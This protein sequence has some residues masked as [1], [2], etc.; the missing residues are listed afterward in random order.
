M[1]QSPLHAALP[2]TA[3]SAA[4]AALLP[5]QQAWARDPSQLKVAEKSRRIGLTWAEA[6]D[7]VL[8][9]AA[10]RDA[11]GMNCYYIGYNMDMAIEYVEACAMWSRIF[12]R[13]AGAI[14]EG[15]EIFR[16]E[17]DAEQRI[18]TYTIRFPSGFRIVALS[19][20]PANLRG[21]QGVVV[22]DEAAFHGRLR[23]LLKAALAQLIWGGRVRIIS[24]HDGESNDFNELVQDIRGGRR[25]GSV[26]R[27]DFREA[28]TQGL[29]RRVCLRRGVEWS[30]AAERA[31]IDDVYRFYGSAA[32]EELDVI[33]SQGSGT[34][35]GSQLIEARMVD[36]PVLRYA[37][38]DGFE[39][40]PD[41]VRYGAVQDWLDTAVR[42]LLQTLDP[43]ATSVYGQDFGRSG[44]LTV[45]APAQI[46]QQLRRRVP[47]MLEL[48]NMP[49]REQLQVNRYVLHRLPQLRRVALD[50]RGNG[51]ALAEMLAQDF[52]WDRVA[53]VMLTEGWYREHMPPLRVAFEDD[54]ISLPRDRDILQ[55]LRAVT[56]IRGV[57]RVPD[58]KSTGG[59]GGQRHGDSAIALA[60]MH[61]A[62][63]T[64][65]DIDLSQIQ[66]ALRRSGPA[67]MGT[68]EHTRT[69]WGTVRRAR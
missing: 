59:D 13:A 24:T 32:A 41:S 31:W 40:Q 67:M 21:K 33:P 38:P 2:N 47:F 36:A 5:Y 17:A 16:D 48:R 54:A 25:L 7:N 6:S 63:R 62:S 60:L 64:I 22:V 61:Y 52:G 11:G 45:G 68:M 58:G 28:V 43:Y 37:C 29:Y 46:D 55:D 8:T 49:H 35:L 42:P 66:T 1:T 27:I 19:S 57:P 18:K 50:A 14:E 10:A 3:R 4:P 69:G 34:W 15:E 56:M 44:D 39:R 20:R 30:A 51:H 23:E 12:D 53:L 26:H 65:G 9:A